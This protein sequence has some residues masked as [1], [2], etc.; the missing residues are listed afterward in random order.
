MKKYLT[1]SGLL[2]TI[3]IVAYLAW[4][5]WNPMFIWCLLAVWV[6]NN[7]IPLIVHHHW[8]H[9]YTQPRFK[10]LGY[11]LD[12]YAYAITV[13]GSKEYS[14]KAHWRYF[15]I[16]HHQLW[17]TEHDHIE[18]M[19][20]HT[21]PLILWFGNTS[22]EVM[23]N[24][25]HPL[26]I[27]QAKEQTFKDLTP[28]ERWIDEHNPLIKFLIH[29]I[30]FL[31]FGWEIYFYI[32]FIPAWSFKP[33]MHFFTETLAHWKKKQREDEYNIPWLFPLLGDNAFHYSHHAER[34]VIHIGKGA[35]K[36]FHINYW[37]I[38]LFY[39]QL[40]PMR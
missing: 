6:V 32:L 21:H 8:A 11:I 37:F 7:T 12:L 3:F 14:N 26:I 34:G 28:L 29:L 9:R 22:M 18:Y 33:W 10:W 35:W 1:D 36:Y 25:Q 17:K 38:R 27:K 30:F 2:T 5:W 19:I 20:N 39:K 4:D 15:H 16:K 31:L 23:P 24:A 40:V 13:S